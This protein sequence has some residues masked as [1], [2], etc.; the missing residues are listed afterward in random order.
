MLCSPATMWQL[1]LRTFVAAKCTSGGAI[2]SLLVKDF[3][4]PRQLLLT[5]KKKKERKKKIK[6]IKTKPWGSFKSQD[7]VYFKS[8]DQVYSNKSASH[9]CS[10]KYLRF[11][12]CSCLATAKARGSSVAE[13]LICC[14][15][16]APVPRPPKQPAKF[17]LAAPNMCLQLQG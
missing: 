6:Q 4:F 14:C 8:E 17:T 13:R 16:W 2:L 7:Q 10:I 1:Q 15:K 12:F 9:F 3:A 11:L 5:E